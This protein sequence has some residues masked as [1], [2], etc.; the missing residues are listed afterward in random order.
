M[1][2][3]GRAVGAVQLADVRWLIVRRPQRETLMPQL[4]QVG[5]LSLPVVALTG[6]F[7]GMVLAQQSYSQFKQLNLE[8]QLGAADQLLAGA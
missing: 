7:I 8:T 1:R 6:T 2:G 4:Y 3:D 5:V